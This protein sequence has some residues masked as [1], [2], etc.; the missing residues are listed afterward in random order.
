MRQGARYGSILLVRRLSFRSGG[1][2][3]KGGVLTGAQ[4]CGFDSVA[5]R[6]SLDS[7]GSPFRSAFNSFP[8][9]K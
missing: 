4:V 2:R 3:G 8:I 1:R 9:L 5:E 7:V 6:G